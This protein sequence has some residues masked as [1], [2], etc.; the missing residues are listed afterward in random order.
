MT[1][2]A[3]RVRTQEIPANLQ[4]L[5]AHSSST[6]ALVSDTRDETGLLAA[7]SADALALIRPH[8]QKRSLSAGDV[9]PDN[10]GTERQVYFPTCGLLSITVGASEDAVE[11]AS[12]S[13]EGGVGLYELA[14]HRPVTRT[15]VVVGGT[16]SCMQAHLFAQLEKRHE[17]LAAIGILCRD[18]ISLQAQ[19]MAV[20]NARHSAEARFSR[21]LL[22]AAER[23]ECDILPMTQENIAGL[24]GLRRTSVTLIAQKLQDA[25]VIK[26]SRGKIAVRNIAALRSAGCD[27][28][29]VLGQD[30][31]PSERFGHRFERAQMTSRRA[32]TVT[33]AVLAAGHQQ[34][35]K[36]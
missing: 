19:H 10:G 31:W 36:P 2:E 15:E 20:C 12:I 21:W 18:W 32:A 33:A 9:L 25:D 3:P 8:L 34:I 29:R 22:L 24:L 11:V 35:L 1:V 4:R 28:C 7:L 23:M 6:A 14:D 13:R 17:E 30:A 16:F 5:T 26:Y 27:C